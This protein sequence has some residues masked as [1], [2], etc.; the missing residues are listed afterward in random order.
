LILEN[1][2]AKIYFYNYMNNTFSEL[3]LSQALLRG[4]EA[5]G[6]E[7]PTPI[8]SQIIPKVLTKQTDIVG[9]AQTGTG[10][11][12]AFGLPM[13]QMIDV[14]E[15]EVQALILSPT[16]EL[17]LQ[18][19]EELISFGQFI[20][21]LKITAVYGGA[22]IVR[23]MKEI[24]QGAQIVVAT[25][26][27][28]RDLINRNAINLETV[29][30][31]VLDEADE[32]LNMGFKEEL[33]DILTNVPTSRNTWLFSATMPDE[34]KRIANSY[35]N[36]PMEVRVGEK[37][38]VN[39]D[40][41]HQYVL[42]HKSLKYDVLRRFLDFTSDTH[43]LVFCRTRMDCAELSEQLVKDGYN[44]DALHGDLN[45]NQRDRVMGKFK[46]QHLQVLVATDVAA[47]GI[48]VQNITHVFHYNIPDDMAFYTHR[49]GR[50]GRAGSKGISLILAHPKEEHII[51]AMNKSLNIAITQAHIPTGREICEHRLIAHVKHIKGVEVS[52]DLQSFMPKIMETLGDLTKE[53]VIERMAS[54]NFNNFWEV[55]QNAP[56][57]NA[58]KKD[59]NLKGRTT[60]R[61]FI[62]IGAFDVEGK[63]GFLSLVCNEA[64][65]SSSSI[66]HIEFKKKFTF[67]EVE[68][69]AA[70]RILKTFD[71][72]MF[73][74]RPVR[75]N[76]DDTPQTERTERSEK[77]GRL[78]RPERSASRE[79]FD[80]APKMERSNGKFE[81]RSDKAPKRFETATNGQ[82]SKFAFA[83]KENGRKK[84][85]RK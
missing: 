21:G 52:E 58:S 29:E 69:E 44:A 5:L 27:R 38:E 2:K 4:V 46:S 17:C 79:R 65:I 1:Q 61:L 28:L 13:L 9:L 39:K 35:M 68:T 25:P 45:Q 8:Q 19:S 34:V 50:T 78:D 80:K 81:G 20:K 26:G 76:I 33:D 7:T 24:K 74:G 6:Y 49:S 84:R 55:Y 16:R 41:D 59:K 54:L 77:S 82:K 47:R 37:N 11:T 71:G 60:K 73:D 64:R 85:T 72:A 62:N 57:L 3:G 66:G 40:I 12:A 32:M 42:V 48:D 51:R 75:I 36:D 83:E 22:D 14:H 18:I 56:D 53:E 70:E 63:A 10:K 43:C 30:L 31:V 23:Q 67:F 15:A